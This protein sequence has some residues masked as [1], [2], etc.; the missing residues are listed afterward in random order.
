[1][2]S[3]LVLLTLTAS[4]TAAQTLP[5]ATAIQFGQVPA[6]VLPPPVVAGDS[7]P[8]SPA[9]RVVYFDSQQKVGPHGTEN[10]FAYRIKVLKPEGLAVGNVNVTWN[11]SAGGLMVHRLNIVRDGQ[12]IDVLKSNRFQVLQREGGLEQATLNGE[13]TAALQTPG[14]SV[15][16]ELEFA[17]TIQMLDPTLGDHAFGMDQL[18]VVGQPGSFRLRL[19]WDASHHLNCKATPDLVGL[20][21]KTHGSQTELL[22]ELDNPKS[23]TMTDKA[24]QR[25]NVRRQIE[26]SD[27]ASWEDLSR[28]VWSLYAK[29]TTLAPDSPVRQAALKIAARTSDPAARAIAALQL[30][31]EEVRYVYVGMNGGNYHPATAD[32]TWQRR[33]GDCKGKAALLLALLRELGVPAEAALVN[34][35]NGDGIDQR[36]PNPEAFDHVVI[37]VTLN[38]KSYWLDGT[39]VGNLSLENL[40]APVFRWAL[41]LR[42]Q[43]ASLLAVPLEPPDKPQLIQIIDLD[44]SAGF[45]QPAEMKLTQILRGD[46]ASE[47]RVSLSSMSSA[48]VD[49]ALKNYWS[50]ADGDPR[51][52]TVAWHYDEKNEALILSVAGKSKM[53][54]DGAADSGRSFTIP[55]AGFFP[56]EELKRP[57]EQDQTAPWATSYPRFRCWVT[58]VRL[59]ADSAWAWSYSSSPVDRQLGGVAYWRTADLRGNVMRT[60]MSSRNYLPEISAAQAAEVNAAIQGFDNKMSVVYQ[61]SPAQQAAPALKT[62]PPFDDKTDWL[63]STALCS[64]PNI[65]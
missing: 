4:L 25:F 49:Q 37:H 29:A 48:Q 26:Y 64:S 2:R 45:D 52:D 19:L 21:P 27:Y 9:V 62:P 56:P 33:F 12:V 6:W 20:A 5:D 55:G 3:A 16:D 43:G 50:Q 17:A 63:A 35:E 57:N 54:W 32:E 15:G 59:P 42:S 40:P 39:N 8:E 24:P 65:R 47:F 38:G 60:I 31:Q 53:P 11:P 14:L 18:P 1:M 46:Q 41:P 7:S 44:A 51:P 10:Y 58:T 22:Y 28:E 61:V 13:L 23:A 36:L 34:A 30:V